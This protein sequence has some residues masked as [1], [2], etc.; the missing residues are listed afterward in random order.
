MV[1]EAGGGEEREK[2]PVGCLGYDRTGEGG[3]KKNAKLILRS[4][5]SVLC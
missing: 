5:W 2:D 1:L 4:M 3:E